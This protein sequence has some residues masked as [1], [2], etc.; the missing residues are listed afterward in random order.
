MQ[1]QQQQIPE[2]RQRKFDKGFQE[3][4][5]QQKEV[6]QTLTYRHQVTES[7]VVFSP[8][9]LWSAIDNF[10]NV[11]DEDLILVSYVR[12]YTDVYNIDCEDLADSKKIHLELQNTAS[13]WITCCRKKHAVKVLT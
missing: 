8:N 4:L 7:I 6:I 11:V 2:E 5:S 1:L 10:S 13:S 9:A 3:L 12:R